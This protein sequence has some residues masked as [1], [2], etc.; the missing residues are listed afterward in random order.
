MEHRG[1]HGEFK[2]ISKPQCVSLDTNPGSVQSVEQDEINH[3]TF[4]PWKDHPPATLAGSHLNPA[5]AP[6]SRSGR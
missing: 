5:P 2:A 6:S 4:T 3:T 1:K